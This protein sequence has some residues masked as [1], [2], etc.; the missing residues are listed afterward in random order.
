M[1]C[2]NSTHHSVSELLGS[3][4]EYLCFQ[5]ICRCTY[6]FSFFRP[7]WL[8]LW[9]DHLT[10]TILGFLRHQWSPIGWTQENDYRQWAA[11][12]VLGMF[13][14]TT[15]F[16]IICILERKQMLLKLH[17]YMYLSIL[18]SGCT[19]WANK[20]GRCRRDI[21][22]YTHSLFFDSLSHASYE[23]K[24]WQKHCLN[25]KMLWRPYPQERDKIQGRRPTSNLFKK[26]DI[27]KHQNI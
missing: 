25:C 15:V 21:Y 5:C 10:H 4:Y 8:V 11:M 23:G 6:S 24:G 17:E 20:K 22:A 27:A 26:Y 18:S 3:Q 12:Q 2:A 9:V 7:K 19:I 13:W 1:C 16:T 14:A